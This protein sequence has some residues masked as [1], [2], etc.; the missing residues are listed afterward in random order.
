MIYAAAGDFMRHGIHAL[1]IR[2]FAPG[3]V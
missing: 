1:S 2:A 3:E